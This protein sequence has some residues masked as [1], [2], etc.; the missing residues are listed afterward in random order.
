LKNL[1]IIQT[2][3][4]PFVEQNQQKYYK[5]HRPRAVRVPLLPHVLSTI[6]PQHILTA[7]SSVMPIHLGF[8]QVVAALDVIGVHSCFGV[9]VELAVVHGEVLPSNDFS[10]VVEGSA[11]VAHH[12]RA[13]LVSSGLVLVVAGRSDGHSSR[14][15]AIVPCLL[16]DYE[17]HARRCAKPMTPYHHGGYLETFL[18]WIWYY[19][20]CTVQR[21]GT[22]ADFTFPHY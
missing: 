22:G 21:D 20:Y 7:I 5:L 17:A 13:G 3:K 10:H 18:F 9:L 11:H 19:I 2:I 6:T 12:R 4:T 15:S 14:P 16:D 8:Y 1:H